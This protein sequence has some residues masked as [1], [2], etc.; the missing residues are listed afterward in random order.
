M[1]ERKR[2]IA[3][4]L[5]D[6]KRDQLRERERAHD[7]TVPMLLMPTYAAIVVTTDDL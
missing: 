1:R 5:R 6:C 7:C 4:D 2:G 3:R